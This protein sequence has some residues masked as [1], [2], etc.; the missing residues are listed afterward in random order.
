MT[1]LTCGLLLLEA[2]HQGCV[3]VNIL[4]Y[5]QIPQ[6]RLV[7]QI[8]LLCWVRLASARSQSFLLG[9]LASPWLVH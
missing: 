2:C 8:R 6:F 4:D 5:L 1:Y 7:A 3:P 9:G